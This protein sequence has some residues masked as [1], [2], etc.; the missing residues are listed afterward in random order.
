MGEGDKPE[1]PATPE[2]KHKAVIVAAL[3][4]AL[5]I[6]VVIIIALA[7]FLPD[8]LKTTKPGGTTLVGNDSSQQVAPNLGMIGVGKPGASS[9]LSKD[10]AAQAVIEDAFEGGDEI[11]YIF[12]KQLDLGDAV[13]PEGEEDKYSVAGPVWFAYVDEEPWAFFEHDVKYMFIDASTGE[14]TVFNESWPPDINGESIF[15][16]EDACGGMTQILAS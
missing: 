13:A 8:L 12:C 16:A 7:I 2:R 6:I 4:A 5:V 9:T 3:V 15:E 14:K 1:K 11:A 10:G